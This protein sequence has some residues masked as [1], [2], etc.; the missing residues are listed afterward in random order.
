MRGS[1]QQRGAEERHEAGVSLGRSLDGLRVRLHFARL[2]F[3]IDRRL[4][5]VLVLTTAFAVA[6]P[7][8]L[9]IATGVVIARVVALAGDQYRDL[10][11]VG[12][13]VVALA[14]LLGIR[15]MIDLIE[16]YAS[17]ALST[18][19]SSVL[20]RRVMSAA[21]APHVVTHF[22]DP[23]HLEQVMRAGGVQTNRY[24]PQGAVRAM[25]FLIGARS[26][27]F[28]AAMYVALFNPFIA[29]GL[30]FCWW[31][32]RQ[33]TFDITRRQYQALT[34]EATAMRRSIYL[35]ELALG[36]EVAKETRVFGLGNWMIDQY[37]DA[38]TA[39]LGP[40]L[41]ARSQTRKISMWLGFLA[42]GY[43]IAFLELARAG[44]AS[45]L[46]IVRFAATAQAL[47]AMAALGA[48]RLDALSVVQGVEVLP[49]VDRLEA[50][51]ASFTSTAGGQPAAGIRRVSL[52]GVAYR[53]PGHRDRVLEGLT[54][55]IEAGESLAI[56]GSNGAG[57]TTLV[58]LLAG[59]ETPSAGRITV[60]DVDLADISA[61]RWHQQVAVVFQS[62]E[63]YPV[64]AAQNIAYGAAH[65]A[66]DDEAVRRAAQRAGAHEMIMKLPC[67][68][69]TVLS[70]AFYG[71]V[72]LSGG[73]WQRI[74]ISRALYAVEKGATLLVLDEPTSNLDVR[75]EAELFSRFVELTAG[76]T[77]ILISHRFATVRQAKRIVVLH[78][79]GIIEDGSHDEL[80]AADGHY[81]RMFRLQASAYADD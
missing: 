19:L 17:E 80:V 24:T 16:E 11:S 74:A 10:S 36:N 77:T 46:S 73:Q 60:D 4:C 62:F 33:L 30:V 50:M 14:V 56:V 78:E 48:A 27:G 42:I 12:G 71:G 43:T 35:R 79:G 34:Y 49:E 81:A 61:E 58:K 20:A 68:Y 76:L 8:A 9:A 72:D 51:A 1:L 66:H 37:R 23:E 52:E 29:T 13:A 25:V 5:L 28:L 65:V 39:A 21:M 7:T 57:K 44:L 69:D 53:Y 31:G 38:L 41:K 55:E 2:L 6:F 40:T 64:T 26:S 3:G 54:L 63:R 18:R 15:Q 47:V 70:P 59:L 67:G 22:E 45:D 32:V 75:A